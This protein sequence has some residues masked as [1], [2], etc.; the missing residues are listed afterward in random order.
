MVERI[1]HPFRQDDV[2]IFAR[3]PMPQQPSSFDLLAGILNQFALDKFHIQLKQVLGHWTKCDARL[4]EMS[5]RIQSLIGIQRKGDK[6]IEKAL[7]DLTLM[8]SSLQEDLRLI[9]CL[10]MYD[11]LHGY[12]MDQ[13]ERADFL[14]LLHTLQDEESFQEGLAKWLKRLLAKIAEPQVKQQALDIAGG[15]IQNKMDEVDVEIPNSPR[16]LAPPFKERGVVVMSMCDMPFHLQPHSL[17][18]PIAPVTPKPI[19]P[20]AHVPAQRPIPAIS[21]A[22]SPVISIGK[23][24]VPLPS[25]EQRYKKM[26]AELADA[27]KSLDAIKISIQHLRAEMDPIQKSRP[28]IR[29]LFDL[30]AS[31]FGRLLSPSLGMGHQ[32]REVRLNKQAAPAA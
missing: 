4:I 12:G 9:K 5:L 3:H 26:D 22:I 24:P 11:L 28:I 27:K 6:E 23:Y 32:I 15:I 18:A 7:M 8:P 29:R 2:G 13:E 30:L 10:Q 1:Q 16:A 14:T 31:L 21:P 25:H 20:L 19:A 17:L